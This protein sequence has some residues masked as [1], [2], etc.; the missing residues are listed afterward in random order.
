VRCQ[1]GATYILHV[2][3]SMRTKGLKEVLRWFITNDL[4][5]LIGEKALSGRIPAVQWGQAL[6]PLCTPAAASA[7]ASA[8]VSISAAAAVASTSAPVL[9]PPLPLLLLPLPQYAPSAT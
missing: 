1:S 8:A 3:T 5:N 6:L 7:A 2:I 9:S 4:D